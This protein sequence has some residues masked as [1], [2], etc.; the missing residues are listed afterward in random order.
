MS[1]GFTTITA[2][3]IQDASGVKMASGRVVWFPL[4]SFI[5]EDGGPVI[6]RAV[7]F[8][9]VAGAI[10]TDIH[11]NDAQVA[12]T[13]LTNPVNTGYRVQVLDENGIDVTPPGWTNVQPHGSSWSLDTFV[14][15]QPE[16]AVLIVGG[17]GGGI[18]GPVAGITFID[19]VTAE[20]INL[21]FASGVMAI[22]EGGADIGTPVGSIT[23]TDTVTGLGVTVSFA[24]G[25]QV[26]T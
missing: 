2:S 26:I 15:A 18:G 9:V 20:H 8:L 3:N 1:T 14:P 22:T 7:I 19:T 17:G 12:D 6:R 10:T 21:T 24:S 25:V 23:F 5:P 11:G 4:N 13:N 16:M